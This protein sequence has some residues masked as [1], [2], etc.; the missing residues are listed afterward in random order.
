MSKKALCV[1]INEYPFQ[2]HGLNGCVN[3]ATAW[4]DLLVNHYGFANKD[5]KLLFDF[6][7]TKSNIIA[8]LNNMLAGATAGDVF[9]FMISSH[10]TYVADPN[11]EGADKYDEVICPYDCERNL[12]MDDEMSEMFSKFPEGVSLTMIS[13]LCHS[14]TMN[15]PVLR[16][17]PD[18]RRVKFLNPE[19][20]KRATLKDPWKAKTKAS[21]ISEDSKIEEL[22]LSGCRSDEYAYDAFINGVYHGAMT[23]YALKVIKDANYKITYHELQRK[24]NTLLDKEG[25]PQ[26]PQ[27]EGRKEN[28]N[29]QL[30]L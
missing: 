17:A 21:K 14:G 23:Y 25:F 16:T 1:G 27:L 12:I 3:D 28:Q 8:S 29:K 22:F 10:G 7:A 20:I 2:K 19:V 5:V 30:F 11:N 9:V 4:G 13:D 6:Q 26:H 15:I 18:N 24:L